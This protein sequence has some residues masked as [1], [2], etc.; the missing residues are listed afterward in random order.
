MDVSFAGR[1]GAV[2]V[3]VAWLEDG[4]LTGD[5]IKL[6]C[7]LSSHTPEY[8]KGLSQKKMS[9]RLGISWA[10][11]GK[12][13]EEMEAQGILTRRVEN[14]GHPPTH[15][16]VIEFDLGKWTGGGG[17]AP[18][19]IGVS[20]DTRTTKV[21]QDL[22]TPSRDVLFE[23]FW[24]S[25]PR[26]RR[27]EK[28]LATVAWIKLKP[29]DRATALSSLGAWLKTLDPQYVPYPER[30]LKRARWT[31]VGDVPEWKPSGVSRGGPPER[32]PGVHPN[33]V[34]RDGKWRS[35]Y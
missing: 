29:E 27:R 28:M 1:P 6:G 2:V 21:S 24:Q 9:E 32:P 10:R 5:S 35:P 25:Y 34:Y 7:W 22:E 26:D 17:I 4:L 11:I 12:C 30:Y 19:A 18:H 3:A 15:R 31:E 33:A 20:R 14:P 13:L 16:V 23:E 8:L